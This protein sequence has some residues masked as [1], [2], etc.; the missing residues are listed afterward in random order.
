MIPSEQEV[1]MTIQE[2]LDQIEQEMEAAAAANDQA[3]CAKLVRDHEDFV[4]L[5]A[6]VGFDQSTE[7]PVRLEK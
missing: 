4:W 6:R 1:G 7:T 2:K 3:K 5:G